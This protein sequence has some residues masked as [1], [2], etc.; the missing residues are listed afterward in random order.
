[1]ERIYF[2]QMQ[3]NN[4]KSNHNKPPVACNIGKKNQLN[5]EI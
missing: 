2:I 1:M 5:I 4:D 3:V